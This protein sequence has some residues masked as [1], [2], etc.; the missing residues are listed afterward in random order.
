MPLRPRC[1]GFTL[2]EL[3]V[4]LTLLGLILGL[5]AP[6]LGAGMPGVSARAAA[7]DVAGVLRA[8]RSQAL[9]EQRTV[10][11]VIDT[12]SRHV[13]FAGRE[14]SLA[15]AVA[16]EMPGVEAA[17]RELRFYPDGS[18]TGVELRVARGAHR[19]RVVLDWLTGD[20]QVV[21]EAGDG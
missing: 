11:V 3:L 1:H 16:L 21:P 12:E 13:G 5:V 8:A 18:S 2:L 15:D 20:V 17:R 14:Q 10:S 19:Y 4:V 7:S 6:R 9:T